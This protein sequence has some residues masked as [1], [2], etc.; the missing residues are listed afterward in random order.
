MI[1]HLGLQCTDA[2]AAAAFY[3]RVFAACGLREAMRIDTPHGP[4]IGLCGPDG[5]PQLWIS[6]A[7]DTG[8][9]PVHLALAAPSREAVDAVF[10]A[11]REAG[12]EILHE[13]R[14][15]PEYHPG[16]YGVFLRDPD[17]NNLEA[18]HHGGP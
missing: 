17:G 15:W 11:A 14:V 1:D 18:V 10:T 6:P 12:A 13:P 7:E 4:V 9:R 3:Q 16:Y 2:E 8:H 5:Q